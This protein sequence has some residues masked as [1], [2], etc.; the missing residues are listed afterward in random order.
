MSIEEKKDQVYNSNGVNVTERIKTKQTLF[1]TDENI[2]ND[3]ANQIKS[4]YYEIF[5]S[6]NTLVGYGVPK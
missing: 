6:N 5:D 3:K 2:A 1:F 4:Y